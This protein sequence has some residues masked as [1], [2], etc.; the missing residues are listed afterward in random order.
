MSFLPSFKL[1]FHREDSRKVEAKRSGKQQRNNEK[2]R[3]ESRR[4]SAGGGGGKPGGT[5]VQRGVEIYVNMETAA[6]EYTLHTLSVFN[7]RFISHVA[8]DTPLFLL[9][10]YIQSIGLPFPPLCHQY[11]AA[12]THCGTNAKNCIVTRSHTLIL[13]LL[14]ST[15][16]P[17]QKPSMGK[18]LFTSQSLFGLS[19]ISCIDATMLL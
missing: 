16:S 11:T 8:S 18:I 12:L 19:Y 7:A 10:S 3:A 2:E 14:H 15:R 17:S 9:S 1:C 6:C 13:F 5:S 4:G